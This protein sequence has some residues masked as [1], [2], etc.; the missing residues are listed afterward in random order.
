MAIVAGIRT[1][2]VIGG[3]AR[4][5]R[6]VVTREAR[7]H[8]LNMVDVERRRPYRC[9]VTRLAVVTGIDVIRCL[10]R[11]AAIGRMTADT[12]IGNAVV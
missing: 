6:V 11:R 3:F 5:R 12:T 9:S 2:K 7:P 4:R 10:R 1:L 8:N